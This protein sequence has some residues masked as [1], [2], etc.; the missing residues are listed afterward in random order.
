MTA[1]CGLP[2]CDCGVVID[3]LDKQNARLLTAAKALW[4]A[5][6][7]P[8]TVMNTDYRQRLL[9][10]T[11]AVITAAHLTASPPGPPR[12]ALTE[13]EQD[14]KRTKPESE[15]AMRGP[16][17]QENCTCGYVIYGM[18]QLTAFLNNELRA[19]AD[20]LRDLIGRGK[21]RGR[22]AALSRLLERV[23]GSIINPEDVDNVAP[24]A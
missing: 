17:K 3:L 6:V 13:G 1:P 24:P 11:D 21:C 19:V 5:V 12:A 18:T 20:E 22:D 2:G 10:E 7:N 23:E 4:V 16:C 14:M 9:L 15:L 8:A